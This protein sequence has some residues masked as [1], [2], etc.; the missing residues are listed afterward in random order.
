[1]ETTKALGSKAPR[2]LPCSVC[3]KEAHA[4]RAKSVAPFAP[5]WVRHRQEIQTCVLT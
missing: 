5:W 3:E 1:M 2:P 4:S